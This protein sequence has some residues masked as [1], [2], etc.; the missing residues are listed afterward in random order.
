M[1]SPE[2]GFYSTQDADSEGEEGAFFVWTVRADPRGP[3]T[4]EDAD[5]FERAY[6]VDDVGNFEGRSV[7]YRAKTDA[8]LAA[9]LGIE[10]AVVAR[11]LA[12]G[13]SASLPGSRGRG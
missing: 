7:L 6:G 4:E 5:L 8:V 12:A 11:R 13:R 2:G 9:S 1:T 10:E 3:G